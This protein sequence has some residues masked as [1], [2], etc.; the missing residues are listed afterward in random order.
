M[1]SFSPNSALLLTASGDRTAKLWSTQTGRCTRTLE[2][3]ADA[4]TSAVFS[5]DGTCLLTVSDDDC[6]ML[7]K[8]ETGE[9]MRTSG[10]RGGL[11]VGGHGG[12]AACLWSAQA[13]EYITTYEGLG[14]CVKSAAFS[15]DGRWILTTSGEA[16]ASLWDPK[17]GE[18]GRVFRNEGPRV[19]TAD[20]SSDS[21]WVVTASSDAAIRLWGADS[22]ECVR[23][24]WAAARP[25][26]SIRVAA[27][28][29]LG[30]PQ[31][32]KA[33]GGPFVGRSSGMA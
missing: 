15:P 8:A 2:G 18:P 11:G 33:V 12:R 20:F 3:F 22:G 27:V 7:W 16:S 13:S 25:G 23:H 14:V 30:R 5:P 21:V 4:V 28:A 10:A 17:T 29:P 32:V 9:C 26:A 6:A 24:F 31:A 19:V 1:A